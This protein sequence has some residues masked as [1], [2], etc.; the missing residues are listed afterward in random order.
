MICYKA[1]SFANVGKTVGIHTLDK[2]YY[3]IEFE[4]AEVAN[5]VLARCPA[6][7]CTW[8]HDFDSSSTPLV[9][10]IGFPVSICFHRLTK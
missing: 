4:T 7:F 5:T 1:S 10:V 6:Y 3:Q 8:H 9:E 2:G